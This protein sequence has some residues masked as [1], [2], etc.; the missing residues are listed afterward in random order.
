MRGNAWEYCLE[1]YRPPDFEPV[2]RGGS[3]SSRAEELDR[4]FR[5]RA[6]SEWSDVDPNRPFS[7]WWFRGGHSQGFRVVRL[8]DAVGPKDREAYR[9]QIKITGLA[10]REHSVKVGL[11]TVLYSRVTGMVHNG[12]DRP[13]DEL[14]L[15][16][17]YLD[18]QGHPH[19]E[20]VANPQSRRATF[21]TCWPVLVNSAHP[22]VHST[23]LRPGERRAF[24]VDLPLSFDGPDAVQSDGFGGSVQFLKFGK[25]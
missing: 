25:E 18:P 2:L 15:K 10:G 8:P 17:Y 1:S 11:S 7:T 5:L 12:G 3:W 13:I 16:V 9:S 19:L 20:D 6:P 22:G 14:G 23:T 21:N 24:S 4:T